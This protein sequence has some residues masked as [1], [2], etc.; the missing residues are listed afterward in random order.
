MQENLSE[1]LIEEIKEVYFGQVHYPAGGTHGPRIQRGIQLFHLISGAV[2]FDIEGQLIA[3]KPGDMCL[4]LPGQQEYHRFSDT[5]ESQHSWCQFD[6]E[7]RPE[8]LNAWLKQGPTVVQCNNDMERFMALGLSLTRTLELS[9]QPTLQALGL[10]LLRYFMAL[11][12]SMSVNEQHLAPPSRAIRSACDYMKANLSKSMGL[13]DVA[14]HS[15]VT[16]N[17]LIVLFRQHLGLTPSRYLWQLRTHHAALLLRR[18]SLPIAQVAEQSGF[19]S[20]FHFSR[21]FKQH[22]DLSPKQFRFAAQQ[23]SGHS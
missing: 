21:V 9:V 13:V 8:H 12:A 2:T 7:T 4:L 23:E 5:E 1:I 6:F 14:E 22:Y 20:A 19:V 18:T 3:L 11:P 17:H 15:H 16:V 10:S